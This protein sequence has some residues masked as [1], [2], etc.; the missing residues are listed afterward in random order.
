MRW[1]L[2]GFRVHHFSN[3]P[4]V[5]TLVSQLTDVLKKSSEGSCNHQGS[6]N[7]LKMTVASTHNL[8]LHSH[9]MLTSHSCHTSHRVQGGFLLIRQR[10]WWHN[11]H[12]RARHRHEVAGPEPNRGWAAGHDQRGGCWWSVDFFYVSVINISSKR[13]WVSWQKREIVSKLISLE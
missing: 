13:C 4:S 1:D 8:Y 10:R 11:H 5:H 6:T 3:F 12:Q 2:L 9:R 7:H